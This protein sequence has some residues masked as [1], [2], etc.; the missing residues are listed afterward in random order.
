MGKAECF[1]K[2]QRCCFITIK[3]GII[4]SADFKR[5]KS[6]HGFFLKSDAI[7]YHHEKESEKIV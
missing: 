4:N 5:I 3:E 2:N 6:L 7:Y 1:S